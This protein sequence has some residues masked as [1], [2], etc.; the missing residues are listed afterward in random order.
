MRIV[1]V[2]CYVVTEK[3]HI[4]ESNMEHICIINRVY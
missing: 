2:P 3:K 1:C 4:Y